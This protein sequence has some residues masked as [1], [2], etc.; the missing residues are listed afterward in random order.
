MTTTHTET[1]QT[2][3]QLQEAKARFSYVVKRALE[4]EPQLVTRSGQPAVYIVAAKTY[5]AEHARHE[6]SRKGVLLSSPCRD[7]ELD[8]RRDQDEGREVVL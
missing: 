5:D 6:I 7:V 8:V 1:G 4:D 2:V 3:W